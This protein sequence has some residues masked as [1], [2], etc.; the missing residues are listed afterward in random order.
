MF[1]IINQQNYIGTSSIQKDLNPV[2]VREKIVI[3]TVL[4]E[5]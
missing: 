4:L 1:V 5:F 2:K 3:T